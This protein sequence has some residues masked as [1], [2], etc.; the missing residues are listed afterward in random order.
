MRKL[1]VI[2]LTLG[3]ISVLAESICKDIADKSIASNYATVQ[4]YIL[5][6]NSEPNEVLTLDNGKSFEIWMGYITKTDQS[7]EKAVVV[8][9]DAKSCEVVAINYLN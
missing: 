8:Q 2:L 7:N 4:G 3:S 5:H 6:T 9:L 1:L